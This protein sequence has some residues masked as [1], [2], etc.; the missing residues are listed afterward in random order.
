MRPNLA[1]YANWDAWEENGGS[2]Y[3]YGG[4]GGM[5]PRY[6]PV[7]VVPGPKGVRGF[8][9]DWVCFGRGRLCGPVLCSGYFTGCL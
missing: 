9:G 1:R 4:F 5:M 6:A 8:N 7:P 3:M 2:P